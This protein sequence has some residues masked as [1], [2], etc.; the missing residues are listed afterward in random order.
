M[1]LSPVLGSVLSLDSAWGILTLPLSLLL[2]LSLPLSLSLKSREKFLKKKRKSIVSSVL[3]CNDFTKRS[4]SG[5]QYSIPY[6]P[7]PSPSD[8][9]PMYVADT[10]VLCLGHFSVQCS[11]S[12]ALILCLLWAVLALCVLVGPR[13]AKFGWGCMCLL[14]RLGARW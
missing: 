1:G 11:D 4:R 7:K 14:G 12:P 6:S 5:L 13:Q 8:E 2:V 10:L 9:Y 3:H